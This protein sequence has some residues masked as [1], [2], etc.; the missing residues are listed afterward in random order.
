MKN[1]WVVGPGL[2]THQLGGCEKVSKWATGAPAV[3]DQSIIDRLNKLNVFVLGHGFSF[4]HKV[5]GLSCNYW[6]WFDPDQSRDARTWL[7][8][9]DKLSRP[10][11]IMLPDFC[12]SKHGFPVS[13][14]LGHLNTYTWEQYYKFLDDLE[15]RQ[16]VNITWIPTE[17]MYKLTVGGHRDNTER[18][19]PNPILADKL[20]KDPHYRFNVH[21]KMCM[22]TVK[23][24]GPLEAAMGGH[25]NKGENLLTLLMLPICHHLRVE[26][27]FIVGFDGAPKRFYNMKSTQIHP[28]H[29]KFRGLDRWL[30]WGEFHNMNLYNI[31]NDPLVAQDDPGAQAV[32]TMS[33]EKALQLSESEI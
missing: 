9:I 8:T 23:N 27:V 28:E 33:L 14:G 5:L 7:T 4:A 17:S 20:V 21:T 24:T 22:G 26:N 2:S 6:S 19:T 29:R 31:F 12:K 15:K 11:N 25:N 30:Q 3:K 18:V 32:P 13:A 16:D 10:V 1:I